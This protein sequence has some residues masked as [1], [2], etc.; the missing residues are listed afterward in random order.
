MQDRNDQTLPP[1]LAV[2]SVAEM[3]AA[4]KAAAELGIRGLNLMETAGGAITATIMAR[5]P[6]RPVTVLC[7]PGHNGGDGYVVARLL[8]EAGWP[9]RIAQLPGKLTGDTAL[10][11]ARWQNVGGEVVPLAL[12]ALDGA[13]LVVDA[14]FGAGLKR[15]LV[16]EVRA[17]VRHIN[18][19]NL[20]CRWRGYSQAAF[21]GDS[22]EIAG[23]GEDGAPPLCRN[24]DLLPPEACPSALS[25][26]RALRRANRGGYRHS[27]A[28]A[29]GDS[30]SHR[31]QHVDAVAS[32]DP[33]MGRP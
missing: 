6:Q 14:L 17:I 4:D 23:G 22:G 24:R 19:S 12:A 13:A 20:P 32:A 33:W 31:A 18:D 5:W 10:S 30:T 9:V 15:P 11:A 21:V 7:G 25:G 16:P 8:R 3:Y 1:E 26:T 29:E 2:L 28:C 27:I